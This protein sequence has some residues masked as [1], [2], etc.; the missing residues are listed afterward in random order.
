[1]VKSVRQGI[2][3]GIRFSYNVCAMTTKANDGYRLRDKKKRNSLIR[4]YAKA[5]PELTLRE[6]AE[7]FH[8]SF[9]RIHQILK[10]SAKGD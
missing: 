8:L 4:T 6:L 10:D 2:D 5:N 7:V 3:R 1:M 9:Q